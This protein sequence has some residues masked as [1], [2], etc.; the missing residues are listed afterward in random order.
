[1]TG[2][3][4]GWRKLFRHSLGGR[5]TEIDVN[6]EIAFHLAMRAERLR[7]RGVGPD[8]AAATA[9]QRF[10]EVEQVWHECVEIDRQLAR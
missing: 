9:R 6:D 10:V 7:T 5:Q 8:D 1:M 3:P 2:R 4:P